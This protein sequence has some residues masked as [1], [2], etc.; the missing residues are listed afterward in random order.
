MKKLLLIDPTLLF[1]FILMINPTFSQSYTPAH[2]YSEPKLLQDFLCSEVTY[3]DKALDQGI[4]GKVVLSFV[5][6]K[7]GSISQVRVKESAGPELDAEARRLFSLLLW[8]PAVSFGQP[9][10]S[11]IEFPINFNI[12]KY[13]KHCKARGY[14]TPDYPFYPI[15]S[16]NVVFDYPEVDKKPYPIFDEKGM[17]LAS[18]IAKSI[19]YPE[20]AYKQSLSGKVTLQFVV[21][22]HGRVSNIK[23]VE[24]VGGGCTQEAIRLL[25]MIRW[26]PGIKNDTAVRT[27]MKLDI[28]FKLAE[29]SDMEMFENNQMNSN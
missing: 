12:K 21:E 5:V 17:N 20:V 3:P 14:T 16:S 28:E 11:E 7:D 27:F 2:P 24:A 25:Q 22:L 23:V 18:F 19:K 8:E 1:F 4:E 6:G 9:V 13:N 29:N 10:A 15:D 26:M